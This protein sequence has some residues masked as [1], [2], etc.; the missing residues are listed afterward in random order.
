L[1]PSASKDK[2][3]DGNDEPLPLNLCDFD[4]ADQIPKIIAPCPMFRG[5]KDD[6]SNDEDDEEG[7]DDAQSL[8]PVP[9]KFQ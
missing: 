8:P 4:D 1:N 2:D 5:N 7:G 9:R 3:F 6:N